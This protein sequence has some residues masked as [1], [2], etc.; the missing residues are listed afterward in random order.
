MQ[1]FANN[2]ICIYRANKHW[3]LAEKTSGDVAESTAAVLIPGSNKGMFRVADNLDNVADSV[4]YVKGGTYVLRNEVDDVVRS[5]RS[6]DLTRRQKEHLRDTD[7]KD[8]TF[9]PVHRTDVY[10][11]QRGLE[12]VLHDT[13][14]PPLNKVRPISLTNIRLPQYLDTADNFLNKGK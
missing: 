14:K 3:Q 1:V 6:N 10:N 11:E 13:Y 7:L 8:Y 4:E 5:G 9:E 12:Q 2:K